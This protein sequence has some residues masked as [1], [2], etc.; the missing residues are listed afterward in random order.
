VRSEL[1]PGDVLSLFVDIFL[2]QQATR[3]GD[4]T[5]GDDLRVFALILARK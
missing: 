5:V 2:E 3:I 4:R 1:A